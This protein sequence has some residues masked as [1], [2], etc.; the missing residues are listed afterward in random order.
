MKACP[1]N[2][3]CYNPQLKD[4]ARELRRNPTQAEKKLWFKL[5]KNRQFQGYR[6]LRQRPCLRYIVD[7]MCKELMLVIEVDGF[8]HQHEDQWKYDQKRQKE[9]EA[10]GFTVLRFKDEQIHED[11]ENVLRKLEGWIAEKGTEPSCS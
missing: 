8:T 1:E 5:L 10:V 3:F 9:L 6:F 7:F 11:F 4:K 2:N